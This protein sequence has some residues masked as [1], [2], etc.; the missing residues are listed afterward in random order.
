MHKERT[1][2]KRY[3]CLKMLLQKVSKRCYRIGPIRQDQTVHFVALSFSAPRHTQ[4]TPNS[5]Y[6]RQTDPTHT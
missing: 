1:G 3:Q 6:L 4:D 5:T 2:K